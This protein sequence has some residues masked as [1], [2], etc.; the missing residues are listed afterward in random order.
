MDR[1]RRWRRSPAATR[2]RWSSRACWSAGSAWASR[3]GRPWICCRPAPRSGSWSSCRRW[4]SGTAVRSARSPDTRCNDRRV[5]IEVG[6]VG[7]TLRANPGGFDAILLD[8]DNGP[9]AFTTPANEGL[10]DNGGVA[11]SYAALRMGGALAV[12]SAWEDRK[13]EQRLR[14]HGFVRA[15]RPRARPSQE[16]RRP[17]HHLSR[18]QDCLSADEARC[19][20]HA[21]AE[22]PSTARIQ[23]GRQR[24]SAES[25]ER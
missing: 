11:A 25:H 5:R 7:F 18:S 10:Y 21:P 12:W 9:S 19:N 6:D 8:V 22:R 14:F 4:S 23:G 2:A 16:G 15:G 24:G 20:A 1:R 13:F 3:C 17:A